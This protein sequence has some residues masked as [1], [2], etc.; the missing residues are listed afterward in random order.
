[1]VTLESLLP[2]YRLI[3]FDAYGVLTYEGGLLPGAREV[4]ERFEREGR[5]FFLLTND[6]SLSPPRISEKYRVEG[7]A[8]LIPDGRVMSP[9]L[10]FTETLRR[11]YPGARV[12]FIGTDESAHY[13]RAAGCTA[14]PVSGLARGQAFEVFVV[15]DELGCDWGTDIRNAS[16][17]L[18]GRP[19]VP[20]FSPNPD[21]VFSR[22]RGEVGIGP[23]ALAA[24]LERIL[25]RGFTY[26]G[27]PHRA[28][29]DYVL[30]RAAV[31]LPGLRASEV[32]MVGDNLRTDIAGAA[33]AGMDTLLVLSWIVPG[34]RVD[35]EIQRTGVRPTFVAESIAG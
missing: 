35:E 30:E 8:S 18:L 3:L 20:L 23:G 17:L 26:F 29:F 4:L 7:R 14:L 28:I 10:L 22:S 24:M 6:A 34:D 19:D 13:V 5:P 9:G 11:R 33:S 32:L 21:L 27:K 12:V 31:E 25:D 15:L 16:N 2:R 1:M